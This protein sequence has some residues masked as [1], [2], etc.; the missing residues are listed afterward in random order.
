M[1]AKNQ[2]LPYLDELVYLVVPDQDAADL[3]FRSGEVDGVDNVK[4]ENYEL[5]RGQPA[6]GPATPFTTS[7]RRSTP[8][9]SGST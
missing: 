6:A 5:V 7:A 2:R 8:T 9:S 3:K 4:P 1:D